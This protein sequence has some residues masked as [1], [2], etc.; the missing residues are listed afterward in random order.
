MKI[1]IIM[2]SYNYADIIGEAIESVINQTYADWE[3]IIIDD[4]SKDDSVEVIKKYLTDARIKLFV[5]EENLGLAKTV[6]KGVEIASS[7]WITF[8]ESDDKF[9]PNALEEKVKAIS[10]G[11]DVIFTGLELFGEEK[12]I[13]FFQQYF[14][15]IGK[16]YIDY[17]TSGFVENFTKILPMINPIPTFSVVMLKKELL[18]KCKFTPFCKSSLDYY[19]WAQ[20]SSFCKFY[21]ISEKLT[22]WRLHKDSYINR[23]KYNWFQKYLFI[24]IIYA[25]TIKN[26]NFLLRC[27]LII[28]YMR[29]RLI[30]LKW[31]KSS[32][33]LN[34]ANNRFIFEKKF[35]Q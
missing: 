4:G 2:A 30:Y 8:L 5:N 11:A 9:F 6:Q 3:L 12:S 35:N 14:D 10:T 22:Y 21:Y 18:R 29:A 1:S 15:E 7:E 25:Q 23:E 27:L 33:K 16:K 20:L 13:Q 26:K 28:N 24:V 19:L 34:L 32:I 17:S 31:D